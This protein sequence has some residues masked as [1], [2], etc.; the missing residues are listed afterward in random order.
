MAFQ[1]SPAVDVKEKDLSTIIP[2]VS[3]TVGGTVQ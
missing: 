3:S 1:V 2:S